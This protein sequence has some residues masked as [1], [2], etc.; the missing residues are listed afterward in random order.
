[1]DEL[2]ACAPAAHRQQ[3]AFGI[4]GGFGSDLVGGVAG[5][6]GAKAGIIFAV[7][8]DCRASRIDPVRGSSAFYRGGVAAARVSSKFSCCRTGRA[9]TE[10]RFCSEYRVMRVRGCLG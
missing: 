9:L 1:M 8:A 2:R 7:G 3:A 10:R 4:V 5:G 6:R